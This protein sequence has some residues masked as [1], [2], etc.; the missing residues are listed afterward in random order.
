MKTELNTYTVKEIT[1]GF[2][3]NE[4]EGKGLF[5]L[6]GKLTIQPEYQRNYIYADGK[7]DVACIDSLMKGYPLGLIYFNKVDKDKYEVLDGQQR[8]TSIGRY[9]NGKFAIELNGNKHYFSGLSR[10]QQELILNSVLLVYECEGTETEIKEWFKT[11]NIS[12]VP[13]NQQELRN[14]IYSGTFVTLAKQEFSNSQNANQQKWQTYIKGVPNRQ[15]ILEEAL[16]WVSKGNIDDYMSKHRNDTDIN[17]LKTYFETVIDWVS[18]VFV[19]V[20]SEMRGLEW[21]RLYEEYHNN[22]YNPTEIEQRLSELYEDSDVSK[23]SG[24]YEYLLSKEKP[25]LIKLL[26]IRAFTETDKKSKYR[27]QSNEAKKS[28]ISNCP[29]CNTDIPYDHMTHIWAYDEMAGDHIVPWS[30]GGK[31]ERNNLQMLCKHHNSLKSNY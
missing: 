26:S 21:G 14:A 29:V 31:T 15:E 13:L 7:R 25:E 5:G 4:F 8:I 16:K 17:E 2:V 9:V 10:E 11:I 6:A 12:G 22:S 18:S 23:K 28:N 1:E 24:I 19:N 3:Y 30:K 20:E 27:E